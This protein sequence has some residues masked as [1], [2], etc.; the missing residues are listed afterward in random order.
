[1]YGVKLK[2]GGA[3]DAEAEDGGGTDEGGGAAP[4]GGTCTKTK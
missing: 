2:A 4:P 1:L 3:V